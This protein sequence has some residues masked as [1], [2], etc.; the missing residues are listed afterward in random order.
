MLATKGKITLFVLFF[1]FCSLAIYS[2]Q[3]IKGFVFGQPANEPLAYASVI[4]IR[5]IGSMTDTSGHF[6]F[7]FP[8]QVKGRDTVTISAVGYHPIRVN[9]RELIAEK[10]VRLDESS[11]ELENV[12]VVS[13]LKGNPLKEWRRMGIR[14]QV[15]NLYQA[16]VEIKIIYFSDYMPLRGGILRHKS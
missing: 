7:W 8:R 9:L 4:S 13:T 10:E 15:Y 5:G 6:S 2:Q 16:F 11:K 3:R 14:K 1:L 12:I